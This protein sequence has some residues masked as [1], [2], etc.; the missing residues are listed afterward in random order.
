MDKVS[1]GD[2][3][4][5]FFRKYEQIRQ[6]N[7]PIMKKVLVKDS[8]WTNFK[9]SRSSPWLNLYVVVVVVVSMFKKNANNF[10]IMRMEVNNNGSLHRKK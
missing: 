3:K 4:Y 7:L 6:Q 10:I 2:N 1:E 5:D 9:T 8:R